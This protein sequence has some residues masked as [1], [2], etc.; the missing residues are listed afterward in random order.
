MPGTQTMSDMESRGNKHVEQF[1]SADQPVAPGS[2]WPR[3]WLVTVAVTCAL[4]G[5]VL[6]VVTFFTALALRFGLGPTVSEPSV[7]LSRPWWIIT[8]GARFMGGW[9]GIGG[10]GLG[11][12][13]MIWSS[14]NGRRSQGAIVAVVFSGLAL[15]FTGLG[16]LLLNEPV[17][18]L[19]GVHE[20]SSA[21]L[22]ALGPRAVVRAYYESADLWAQYWLSDGDRRAFLR[23]SI[24]DTSLLNGVDN[25]HIEKWGG[26]DD[27]TDRS[28][29]ITYVSLATS[30]IGDPPGKQLDLVQLVRK[31]DGPW[32]ISD[33][34]DGI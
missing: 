1:P 2:I 27:R 31:R 6:C 13:V 8:R 3:R 34:S 25:L 7:M 9:A 18:F 32:R 12:A 10:L 26:P 15:T 21:E 24:L 22:D 4:A 29:W 5:F 20:P 23:N 17:Y 11:L 16:T 19:H 33:I 14:R 28:F 30:S